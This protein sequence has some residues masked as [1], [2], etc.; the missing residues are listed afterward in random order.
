MSR[1]T[2]KEF[3]RG[4]EEVVSRYFIKEQECP[5]CKQEAHFVKVVACQPYWRCMS[6]L[7]ILER[8]FVKAK[9]N[10]LPEIDASE[11][12]ERLSIEPD[13]WDIAREATKLRAR[14]IA[15]AAENDKSRL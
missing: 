8:T 5:V 14:K 15:E 3:E 12:A 7:A 13:E 4:V 6:C 11:K 2:D 10:T 9:G 1:Y